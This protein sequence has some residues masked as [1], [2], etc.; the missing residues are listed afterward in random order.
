M[1]YC[2]CTGKAS[3]SDFVDVIQLLG[4]DDLKK[5]FYALDIKQRDIQVA[6]RSSMSPEEDLWAIQVFQKWKE[7]TGGKATRKL[8]LDALRRCNNIE[9][10]EELSDKWKE[11]GKIIIF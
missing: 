10:E 8:I 3:Q 4:P 6:D 7:N 5:L 1:H 9:A 11:R 2:Y